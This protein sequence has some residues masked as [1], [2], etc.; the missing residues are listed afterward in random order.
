MLKPIKINVFYKTKTKFLYKFLWHMRRREEAIK[1]LYVGLSN[2]TNG[3]LFIEM[4]KT[5]SGAELEKT[6]RFWF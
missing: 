6:L 3:M 2:Q 5:V 4:R 1:T